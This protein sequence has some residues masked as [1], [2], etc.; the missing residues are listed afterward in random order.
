MFTHSNW[1]TTFFTIWTGQAFS[2]LSSSVL[3]MA[4][5][6]YLIASSNS[7]SIVALSGI[8]AFLPQGLLGPFIGVYIDR[9]NRKNIMI[10]SDVVIALASLLLVVVGMFTELP[11]WL[12]MVVLFIR[13]VGTA[14][15]TPSLQAITPL[16]V[17][18]DML[19]RC[20]GYSQTFQSISLLI[21]P[22]LAAVLFAIWDLNFII[23]L[24]VLGALLAIL[25]LC[26]VKIPDI[27]RET[28]STPNVLKEAKEGIQALKNKGLLGFTFLGALFS[29]IYMPV[30]VL[31]P[32]MPLSYFEKTTW[33]AGLVE[34]I[35]AVGMLLGSLILGKWGGFKN[36]I[37]MIA[38]AVLMIGGSLA[39]S[40]MLSAHHFLLFL[41]LSAILG[42]AS[43]FFTGIQAVVYQEKIEPQYLG[44]VLSFSGSLMVITTPIGIGLAGIVTEHIGIEKT[45]LFAGVCISIIGLLYR[46]I[47][48]TR[49]NSL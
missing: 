33:H 4:I 30:F 43:P 1:K 6:W 8:V 41:G 16:I 37:T 29:L 34:V 22:A 9:Y 10:I 25:A 5:V 31:F 32:M 28:L 35:F 11:I 27:Q 14:F 38:V 17:P 23:M 36:R 18:N 26:L 49:N 20:A 13:S 7:A 12:I 48:S 47:S 44:R 46:L 21:S 24:D 40:G 39:V 19:T 3:Q 2:Q 15:H 42:F 45:F